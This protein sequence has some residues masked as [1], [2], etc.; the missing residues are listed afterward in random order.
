MSQNWR[1]RYCNIISRFCRIYNEDY[2]NLNTDDRTVI[3]III[4]VTLLEREGVKV[5]QKYTWKKSESNIGDVH[6]SFFR[7]IISFVLF[8]SVGLGRNVA[9]YFTWYI[10]T[11]YTQL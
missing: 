2:N 9:L 7:N 1:R 8:L 10:D 5:G 4:I 6:F 11:I 3:I